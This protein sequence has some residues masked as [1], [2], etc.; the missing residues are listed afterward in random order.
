M[1][2]AV[3][4]AAGQLGSDLCPRLPG[5]VMALTRAHLDLSR[6][7]TLPATLAELRPDV[8]INCA[9]YNFVDRA[10]DEPELAFSV[11]AWGVRELAR[12]CGERGIGLVHLSS[13][14]VFGLDTTRRT[15][16][17]ETDAPGPLSV[18]GLSKLAGEYLVR[19]LCPRHWVIRTCGLYGIHGSGGKG[20]NFV[21]TM[22]QLAEQGKPVRV[23]A[24]QVCTPSYTVDVANAITLLMQSA[25]PGLYHVTNS[26]MTSWHD[27]ART[28]FELAGIAA[29]LTPI[30]SEEFARPA[31][32]PGYSVMGNIAY[33][34]LGLPPLRPWRDALAAYLAERR[35]S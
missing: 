8:V 25:P 31:R 24:D 2:Y 10:E 16:C 28:I 29:D 22:L 33:A 20:S 11:N 7:Q 15:P 34:T 13:D 14:Y 23:V 26:G 19:S 17:A 12:A 21:E 30:N 6:P 27:F 35:R 1:R 18:Y 32:R 5:E 4:G 3:L 9:A